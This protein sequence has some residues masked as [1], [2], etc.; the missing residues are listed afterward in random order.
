MCSFADTKEGRYNPKMDPVIPVYNWRKGSQVTG[1][2]VYLILLGKFKMTFLLVYVSKRCL[3]LLQWVVLTRKHAEV[4]VNDT[5]VFPMFQLHCRVSVQVFHY[6][7]MRRG[8]FFK[9]IK[10]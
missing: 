8:R 3:M 5:T 7:C 9:I 4:V 1:N 6:H 2:T 10:P